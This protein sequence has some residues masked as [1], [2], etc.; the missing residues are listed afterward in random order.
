MSTQSQSVSS[1][2]ARPTAALPETRQLV[3]NARASL[4]LRLYL[5]QL[6]HIPAFF[7]LQYLNKAEDSSERVVELMGQTSAHFFQRPVERT[8]NDPMRF[9]EFC[10]LV[11][12]LPLQLGVER[13]QFFL[14][15][16][17]ALLVGGQAAT[18]EVESTG[19]IADFG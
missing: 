17:K 1:S 9:S 10:L 11:S 13:L 2:G 18:H 3:D 6:G 4:R 19:E 14:L 7:H 15:L 8:E 12:Q 16:L 5:V